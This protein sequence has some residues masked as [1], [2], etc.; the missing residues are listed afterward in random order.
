MSKLSSLPTTPSNTELLDPLRRDSG[1]EFCSEDEDDTCLR[2]AA[3]LIEEGDD[4]HGLEGQHVQDG[5]VVRVVDVVPGDV[6]GQVLLLLHGEHVLHEELLEVLIGEVDAELLE[7]AQ[8]TAPSSGWSRVCWVPPQLQRGAPESGG[9]FAP[10]IC[11]VHT[12][13]SA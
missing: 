9:I 8:A 5:L 12:K 7:A 3:L 10:D 6:L 1:C 13:P 2:E 4:A 11:H